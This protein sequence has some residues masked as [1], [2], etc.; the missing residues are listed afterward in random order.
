MYTP[1]G[2]FFEIVCFIDGIGTCLETRTAHSALTPFQQWLGRRFGKE[3]NFPL[4]WH[5]FI[6]LFPDNDQAIKQ[7]QELY[8]EFFQTC[9][10]N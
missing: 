7:F 10:K 1:T 3:K 9:Q 4:S 6:E 8:Q 2:S 5:E